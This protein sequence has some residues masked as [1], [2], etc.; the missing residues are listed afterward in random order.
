MTT[1]LLE[2]LPTHVQMW[3]LKL[4]LSTCEFC[5]LTLVIRDTHYRIEEPGDPVETE[6]R[7]GGLQ[8]AKALFFC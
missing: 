5:V 7:E 3:V 2:N 8:L 4:R 6:A 1:R